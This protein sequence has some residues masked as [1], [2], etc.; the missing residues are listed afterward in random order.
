M[1]LKTKRNG[2]FSLELKL[3]ICYEGGYLDILVILDNLQNNRRQMK[4]YKGNELE[5]ALNQYEQWK[6][7][8]F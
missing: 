3:N 1:V 6:T 2:Y 7:F 4:T 8:I 5:K